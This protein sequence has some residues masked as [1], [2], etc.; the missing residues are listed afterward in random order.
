MLHL[1]AD[2]CEDF[3]ALPVLRGLKTEKEKFAGAKQTFTIESLMHDG[4]ALQ[5]GTTHNFGDG[6]AKAFGIQYTD[7]ENKLQYVHQTSWGMTSRLIGAVIMV[8]GD[9]NGLALPPLVAPIQVAIIP[10]QQ[11]KEGVLETAAALKARLDKDFR[12]KIDDSDKSPGWKFAE[13]EMKGVPLRLEIGPKDI[14]AGQCVLVRRDNREKTIVA[15]D[16]LE[17]TVAE[18]L[19]DIQ[20]SLYENALKNREERTDSA[21]SVAELKTKLDARPGFIKAAWC[22]DGD[23]EDAVKEQATATSRLIPLE[24]TAQTQD[25]EAQNCFVCGKTAEHTVIWGRAY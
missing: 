12:V 7:K 9:D 20:K 13:Y 25:N 16:D 24:A 4:Q 11:H 5:T 17:Q 19:K 2:F 10:V 6:F 22:G 3:L 14:E 1:Y 23:C 8:H 18:T 21:A 15:F